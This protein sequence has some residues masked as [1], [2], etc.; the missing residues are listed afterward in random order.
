MS[1]MGNFLS[2]PPPQRKSYVNAVW[3]G[4]SDDHI[5]KKEKCIL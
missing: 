4:C 3:E 2:V 1:V 5:N